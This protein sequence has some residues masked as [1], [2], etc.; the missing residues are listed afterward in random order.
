MKKH[1]LLSILLVASSVAI[2]AQSTPSQLNGIYVN[3][4]GEPF[5]GKARIT[6]TSSADSPIQEIEVVNGHL[7]GS[8]RYLFENGSLAELGHYMNGQKEGQWLQYAKE[9]QLIGEA[10]YKQGLKDG[11]WTVW[12]EAGV[13]R[14]HMVYSEGKKVD[15]WKMWDEHAQLVS[16]RIYQD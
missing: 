10:Y 15:T 9:G 6:N 7:H 5:S 13:K 3:E 12:D 11:I 16:E 8:V 14:Y 4:S 1:A 2:T